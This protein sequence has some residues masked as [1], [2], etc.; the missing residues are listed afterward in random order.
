MPSFL[1]I[2]TV[3][4]SIFIM[5]IVK[6]EPV[7]P[8]LIRPKLEI[9]VDD[10]TVVETDPDSVYYNVVE[11]VSSVKDERLLNDDPVCFF[12]FRFNE[13]GGPLRYALKNANRYSGW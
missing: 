13:L 1:S 11:D 2:H 6:A 3:P 5:S 7:E 12:A 9:L 8:Y 10:E 4:T